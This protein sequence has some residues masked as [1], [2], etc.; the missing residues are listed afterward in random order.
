M[1][2]WDYFENFEN[3]FNFFPMKKPLAQSMFEKYIKEKKYP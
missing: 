3:H 1:E 2:K